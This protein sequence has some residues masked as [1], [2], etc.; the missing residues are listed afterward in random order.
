MLFK[1]LWL[2]VALLLALWSM[3]VW[4]V[5]SLA[6]WSLNSLG[7]LTVSPTI[8]EGLA[9]PQWM[10]QWVPPE[11]IVGLKSMAP[12]LLPHI[13]SARA[14]LPAGVVWLSPLAWIAWAIGAILIFIAGLVGHRL[15]SSY[16]REHQT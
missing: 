1:I 13:D 7:S 12:T 14:A 9:L 16:R 15:I 8:G 2:V 11:W 4:A 3:A 10:A 6:A 5:H